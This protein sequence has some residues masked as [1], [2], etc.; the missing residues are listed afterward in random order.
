MNNEEQLT[1]WQR[2]KVC[3][4]I[5]LGCDRTTACN[6]VGITPGQLQAEM[7]RDEELE[8]EIVRSEAGAELRHMGNVHKAAQDEKNWRT[9][10]WWLERRSQDRSGGEEGNPTDEHVAEL[11]DELA[12]IVVEV[13]EDAAL[14]GRLVDRLHQALAGADEALE[15]A[16]LAACSAAP[17]D[18]AA[19]DAETSPKADETSPATDETSPAAAETKEETR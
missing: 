3:E 8:K 6:Y 5:L 17:V 1:Q 12:R 19:A 18:V 10:V 9:S 15:L 2:A 4:V 16:K 13:I 7:E 14:Q 11:V